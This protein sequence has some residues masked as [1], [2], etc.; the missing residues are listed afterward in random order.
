LTTLNA[1]ATEQPVVAMPLLTDQTRATAV[2]D[3]RIPLTIPSSEEFFWRFDWQQGE[4]DTLA[5]LEAGN[6][7]IFDS[8]DPEDIVRWLHEPDESDA[9][10]D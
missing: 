8:E 2:F 10:Q 1:A 5:E 9:D 6:A 7:I 4:R 3:R